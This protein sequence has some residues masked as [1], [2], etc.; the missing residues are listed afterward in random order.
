MPIPETALIVDDEAH[1]RLYVRMV[2]GRLGIVRCLEATS[3]E[4]ALAIV[5]AEQPGLIMLDMHLPGAGGL[6]VLAKIR[7]LDEEVRVIILSGES[8]AG[9]VMAAASQGADGF[10]RKDTPREEIMRQIREILIET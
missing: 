5:E 8:T 7:E 2:L 6:E 9:A 1:V 4:Q 3:L 10:I